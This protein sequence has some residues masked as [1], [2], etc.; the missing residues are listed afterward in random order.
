MGQRAARWMFVAGALSAATGL[1]WAGTRLGRA[2]SERSVPSEREASRL[3]SGRTR[4]SVPEVRTLDEQAGSAYHARLFP[5]E[6]GVVLVTPSGFTTYASDGLVRRQTIELGPAVVVRGGALV[7]W[8]S[9]KLHEVSL[10]GGP[11][12]ALAAVPRPPRY[13]LSSEQRLAWVHTDRQAG[14]SLQTLAAGA[15]RTLYESAD[16]ISAPVVHAADLY[17]VAAARDRSWKVG[18]I[19]RE[20]GHPHWSAPQQGRPPAMLGV[21]H[22]GIYFY[23]GPQRGVRRLT[24]NLQREAPV[25]SGV[26]CSPLA[27]SDRVL[28]AQVGGLFEIP[29]SGA[30]PTFLA[31]ERAGPIT[32]LATTRSG[33]FWVADDGAERLVVRS[34]ALPEP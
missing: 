18:R 16:D 3:D 12:R 26:V 15:V 24:F 23:A 6:S 32:A 22:D 2:P 9:G 11:E 25:R 13:L 1:A 5:D 31:A 29:L 8:R 30:I 10:S 27:V 7:F 4:R 14:S 19:D 21:G 20:G 17:W 28:C 33:S 34:V